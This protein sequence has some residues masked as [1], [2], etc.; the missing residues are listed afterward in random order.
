[1]RALPE[2]Y[3]EIESLFT[4][5]KLKPF[6][7]NTFSLENTGNAFD[8]AENGRPRGKIIVNV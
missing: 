1:M 6:I 8:L 3:A 7:E 2:D 4:S 5:K